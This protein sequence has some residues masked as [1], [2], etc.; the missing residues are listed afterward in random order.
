MELSPDRGLEHSFWTANTKRMNKKTKSIE[1]NKTRW[2]HG[3]RKMNPIHLSTSEKGDSPCGEW[4]IE[5]EHEC[6]VNHEREDEDI[7]C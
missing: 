6:E 7:V 1:L 5:L 2:G 4:I 3:D